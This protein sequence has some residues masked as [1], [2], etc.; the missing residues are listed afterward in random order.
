MWDCQVE[1]YRRENC[2]FGDSD[3]IKLYS[4]C[5]KIDD[6][7]MRHLIFNEAKTILKNVDPKA[8]YRTGS[9][10]KAQ[11]LLPLET[12]SSKL[13]S[14]SAIVIRPLWPDTNTDKEPVKISL[15]AE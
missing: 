1:V 3:I 4:H 13:R 8:S 14:F 9:V 10:Y 2:T 12:Q 15:R 6:V 5:V 11:E 7:R